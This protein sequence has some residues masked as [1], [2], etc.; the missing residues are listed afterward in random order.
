MKLN[1]S[2]LSPSHPL[3]LS[4]SLSLSI[5]TTTPEYLAGIRHRAIDC[6]FLELEE[7]VEEMR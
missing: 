6:E 4:L 2:L 1:V 3:S 5:I 7:L